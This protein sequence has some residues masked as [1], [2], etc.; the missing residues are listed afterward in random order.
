MASCTLFH[1]PGARSAALEVAY[2]SGRLLESPIGDEGLKVEEARRAVS[3]LQSVPV[4]TELGV[5]VVGPMDQANPKAS[6]VILKTIEEFHADY[7]RP[8]LW[9][10][11]LGGV[12][13]TIRSRCLAKWAPPTEEEEDET[14]TQ[15]GWDLVSASIEGAL[16]RLPALISD[17]KGKELKLL[18][19]VSDVLYM[20]AGDP[21]SRHLWESVRRVAQHRNPTPIE[22]LSAFLP[23]GQS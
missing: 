2:R 19:A 13:P 3:L 5:V 22:V 12:V 1:G 10:E 16:W 14:L 9:A 4:G 6:D 7:V 20:Q 11:D 21:V 17:F 18:Q 15:A 8:I 23:G